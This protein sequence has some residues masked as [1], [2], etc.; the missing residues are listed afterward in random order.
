MSSFSI[1]PDIRIASTLPAAFYKDEVLFEQMKE[2]VFA[3]SWQLIGQ[4]N[5]V[6][7]SESMYPF[8]ML[9]GFLDEPLLLTKDAQD[10]VHCM[11]NVCTHRGALLVVNPGRTKKLSCQYHG[12]RF[13]LDGSFEHMPEFGDARDFPRNCDSLH[14]L[15]LKSWF[16]FLLPR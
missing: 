4:E 5:L 12:R 13:A 16:G 2:T 9:E 1:D 3:R 14:Q 7:L 15:D 10:K 6:G 8:T 11:S